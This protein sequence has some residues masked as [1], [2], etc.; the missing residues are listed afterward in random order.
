M[1]NRTQKISKNF[2]EET[3]WKKSLY[4]CGIDE[5]GRGCLA[6]P[7]VTSAVILPQNIKHKLLKDSKTLS[8]EQ[9]ELAYEWI[10]KN[11]FYSVA[12]SSHK[13]I[14]TLN[15]YNATLQTMKKALLQLLHT[16]PFKQEK[17]KSVLIDAM[18]LSLNNAYSSKNLEFHYFNYGET[19]SS[20]IAAASI[21][22]K[23]ERDRLITKMAPL[24]PNFDLQEH[25]GYGTKKHLNVL[26]CHGPTIIHRK[27]FIY[28]ILK[29]KVDET[30]QQSLF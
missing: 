3:A 23:V 13:I 25:K 21:V 15:I 28:K 30:K 12:I 29:D 10:T 8:K 1:E 5:V 24:F 9:R 22:A 26:D 16:V 6:G 7:L 2:F 11:C 27:T 4:V 18:P 19:I 14:D 20:S 17:I